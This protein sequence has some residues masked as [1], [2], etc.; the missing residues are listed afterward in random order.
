MQYVKT[1][2]SEAEISAIQDARKRCR[3]NSQEDA[4]ENKKREE[5]IKHLDVAVDRMVDSTWHDT[6]TQKI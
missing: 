1:W 3:P 4:I 6:L 5:I 2:I